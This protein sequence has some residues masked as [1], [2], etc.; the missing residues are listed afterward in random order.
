MAEV[1]C[2]TKSSPHSRQ[3]GLSRERAEIHRYTEIPLRH[4]TPL[5]SYGQAESVRARLLRPPFCKFPYSHYSYQAPALAL[6]CVVRILN[7]SS[8]HIGKRRKSIRRKSIR[9]PRLPRERERARASNC[10]ARNCIRGGDF[11]HPG[12]T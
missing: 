4:E 12:T 1:R 8:S 6:S 5:R 9:R 11:Q 10:W 7:S 3:A 2:W